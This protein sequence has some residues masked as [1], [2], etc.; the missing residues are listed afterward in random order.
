MATTGGR[1][2]EYNKF[3]NLYMHFF[4]V[5]VTWAFSSFKMAS[6]G[7]GHL[8]SQHDCTGGHVY[9][10]LVKVKRTPPECGTVPLSRLQL[11]SNLT[12]DSTNGH[13]VNGQPFCHC[14]KQSCLF[15]EVALD[16]A[17][18]SV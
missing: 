12:N 6:M 9:S 13:E 4:V 15:V 11:L 18:S 2:I 10:M 3:T 16:F 14:S 8:V 7:Q 5:S 1:N 17:L